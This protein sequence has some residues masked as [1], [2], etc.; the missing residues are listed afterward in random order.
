METRSWICAR[1]GAERDA[2]LARVEELE[3][4]LAEAIRQRD[5]ARVDLGEYEKMYRVWN[6][7]GIAPPREC[8]LAAARESGITIE[9]IIAEIEADGRAG[10][11]GA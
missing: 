5:E 4:Q 7:D 6:E 8:E 3:G 1:C 9:Q 11:G 10:T 2:L